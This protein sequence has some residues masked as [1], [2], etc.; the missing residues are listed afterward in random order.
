[1]TFFFGVNLLDKNG[2]DVWDPM[3]LGKVEWSPNLDISSKNS[4]KFLQKFCQ[5]LKEADFVKASQVSCWFDDFEKYILE[6]NPINA[7]P[8]SEPVAL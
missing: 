7:I 8:N 1:M 5:D 4:Q 3:D 2:V 6:V